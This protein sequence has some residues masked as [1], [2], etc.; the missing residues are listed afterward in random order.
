M[1]RDTLRI[2][3]LVLAAVGALF[4]A[5]AEA[6]NFRPA[7]VPNGTSIGCVLCHVNPAGGGVRN[8]FGQDVGA[9]T[10]SANKAFW[11]AALAAK[12]SD[13]DGVS[14]GVELGDPEGDFTTLAGWVATLPGDPASKPVVENQPPEFTSTPLTSAIAGLAYSYHATATDPEGTSLSFTKLVGPEWL[15]V[16]ADG[17]VSGT[18]PTAA[19]GDFAVTL[20][21]TDSGSPAR[22]ADQ[23]YSLAVT[24]GFAGWQARHF[25]L[26]A[27]AALAAPLVDADGDGLPNLAEYAYRFHPR[28]PNAWTPALPVFAANGDITLTVEVRDDDPKLEV[29]LEAATTVGYTTPGTGSLT[30]SDP[31]PGDGL[32]T[33]VFKDSVSLPQAGSERFWRFKLELKP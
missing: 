21:V 13:G 18:P 8:K 22:F 19:A 17:L 9:I 12:D 24:G 20:R 27:E 1:T 29:T 31:T 23:T 15:A 11:N 30:V 6:R 10:G 26:P 28:L 33:M 3:A 7:Q 25:T 2:H 4:T 16:A 32:Q 5:P 14:N